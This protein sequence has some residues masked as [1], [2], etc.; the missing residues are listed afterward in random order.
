VNPPER[1]AW[2]LLRCYAGCSFKAVL[3]A[4][5]ERGLVPARAAFVVGG[6]RHYRE[7]TPGGKR[8]TWDSGAKPRAALYRAEVLASLAPG[9][10]VLVCEGEGATEAAVSLGFAA[11]GTACGASSVPEAAALA[12]LRGF[13]VVLAP[14]A[15]E[16]GRAHMT[17][18]AQSLAELGIGARWLDIPGLPDKGD[19]ADYSGS[20]EALRALVDSAPEWRPAP[21][22]QGAGL[23]FVSAR[24]L[25]E[26]TP[27][28]PEW[29]VTGLAARGAI[30]E[31]SAKIKVGKSTLWASLVRSVLAG[32]PFLDR[33]TARCPVVLLTEEREATVRALL[34]RAGIGAS[35]DLYIL[36]RHG[37]RDMDW[38]DIM[39]AAAAFATA[40]EAGLLI[41]DTLPAWAGIVG[42]AENNAGDALAAMAPLAEA[43]AAGL[44]VLAVRHDR[45]GGG[46]LGDSA[47]GS[48]AYGGAAD[49]LLGL[50]RADTPGH[51]NR[52]QLVG[53]GRFDEVPETLVIELR[54]GRYVSL[55]DGADVERQE[56]RAGILANLP[57]D[58]DGLLSEGDLVALLE[59]QAARSTV[60]RALDELV[61]AG[62]I[63]KR[64]KGAGSSGRAA[65]FARAGD[66]VSTPVFDPGQLSRD[67]VSDGD[68]HPK[69]AG[70][71]GSGVAA[72]SRLSSPQPTGGQCA[73][74]GAAI[75]PEAFNRV[76]CEACARAHARALIEAGGVSA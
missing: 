29:V 76:R 57:A 71:E 18:V 66:R 49:I 73:D 41:V 44:A 7:D 35:D 63:V 58:G 54:D 8:V 75:D 32:E 72:G 27:E 59:G 68:E 14:D 39:A 23:P 40:R 42:D 11:V 70:T 53:V 24:E 17:R 37:A 61:S 67:F 19:L 46:E 12:V 9:T 16:P 13:A 25:C 2:P 64:P 38:A 22:R 6:A 45:K 43:A 52:R 10:T 74:C 30:T 34:G 26:R 21:S 51:E 1:T 28:R 31:L 69:A 56:A 55:G 62:A 50:R 5:R 33:E 20:Q 65:G 47:R 36:T 60:R 48:S 3:G 15:D 4:L